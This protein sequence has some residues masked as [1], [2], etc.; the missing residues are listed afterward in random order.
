M[1]YL[2]ELSKRKR[3]WCGLRLVS[4]VYFISTACT[5]SIWF[6]LPR[7]Y[8][9][10]SNDMHWFVDL[11]RRINVQFE[12]F[13]IRYRLPLMCYVVFDLIYCSAMYP[14]LPLLELE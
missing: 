11:N 13:D 14:L 7:V 2:D 5:F 8:S 10:L 1:H 12:P 4:I 6:R 9:T 3:I